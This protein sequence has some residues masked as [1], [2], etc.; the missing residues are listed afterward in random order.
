MV[1]KQYFKG[2]AK[3]GPMLA[4]FDESQ[5]ITQVEQ[6]LR[7]HGYEE[8][9]TLDYLGGDYRLFQLKKGHRYST[10][11]VLVAYYGTFFAPCPRRVLDLGSGI[12]SV[13]L[14]CAW[15]LQGAQI[16]SIEAQEVSVLLAQAS[17]AL[18]GLSHRYQVRHAD[19]R[20]SHALR[21]EEKFDLILASPPYFSPGTGQLG[22][23]PQKIACRFETRGSILDYCQQ[24]A[25]H[26]DFGG[27]LSCVFPIGQK[28]QLEKVIRAADEAGLVII[29]ER[30]VVFKDGEPPLLGLF[31]MMKK[32]DLPADTAWR[33]WQMPA[34]CIR[35]EAQQVTPEYAAIKMAMG[36]LPF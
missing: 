13:G 17:V 30:P 8:S 29:H 16:V 33:A 4:D 1:V 2:F 31:A 12:G 26:L 19:L 25:L 22:D 36:F 21:Q 10:D 24:A 3:P 23:H 9:V 6:I 18:N 7:E 27:I 5:A 34:L 15:R 28:E 14:M 35:D 32:T 11:D 20:D